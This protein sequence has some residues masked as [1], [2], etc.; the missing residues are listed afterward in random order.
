[1]RP[2][3]ISLVLV[4]GALLLACEQG[5]KPPLKTAVDSPNGENGKDPSAH[6]MSPAAKIQKGDSGSATAG[7]IQID[8]RILKACGDLKV[9]QFAFDSASVSGEAVETLSAL[10]RCF[11]SGPLAG[12]KMT[13]VGHADPRGGV[14]YNIALGQQRAGS[15]ATFLSQRGLSEERM[16][17]LSKGAFE[18]AGTD[19][20][21][22]A[23]DRK[24]EVF[25][26]E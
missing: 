16:G 4:S 2:L 9:A 3:N 1:M 21:G 19:E 10:A 23:Q 20:D 24:V 12:S 17:T 11:V 22:W 13:L 5:P 7:S 14:A 25:L 15:V 26:A 6:W 8:P 18:A